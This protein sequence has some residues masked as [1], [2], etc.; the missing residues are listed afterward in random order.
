MTAE[1]IVAARAE[2]RNALHRACARTLSEGALKK[3]EIIECL[4]S[5]KSFYVQDLTREL[6]L[7]E[8][9]LQP[10]QEFTARPQI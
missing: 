6:L 8:F 5:V 2:L 9:N 3:G 4:E 10:R 1:E 7:A